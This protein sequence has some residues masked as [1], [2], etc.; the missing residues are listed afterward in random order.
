MVLASRV[1]QKGLT[2]NCSLVWKEKENADQSIWR[3]NMDINLC[4]DLKKYEKEE[5]AM[6]VATMIMWYVPALNF[7]AF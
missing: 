1:I 3:Y 5:I 7:K 4:E 2:K 6:N